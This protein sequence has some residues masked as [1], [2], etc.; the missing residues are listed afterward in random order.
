[1]AKIIGL[2]GGIGSGKTKVADYLTQK[3]IPVYIADVEAKKIL[4]KPDVIQK[5]TDEIGGI[6]LVE[7][8]IDRKSLANTVFNNPE[9]LQKLNNI[10][11]PEVQKHFTDWVTIHKS[12]PIV[13]K[14]AAILFESGSYKQCDAVITITAPVE[15]R[16]KRVMK[17]DNVSYEDV[18]RRMEN[19]WTDEERVKFS[20]YAIENVNFNQTKKHL[21]KILKELII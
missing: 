6:T 18:L 3:G 2:T 20:D 10:I 4:D 19:Q 16:I 11:H 12:Y 15:E 14:E 21:D 1:M 7:G 9:K 8:K 5:I 13:V 17:R